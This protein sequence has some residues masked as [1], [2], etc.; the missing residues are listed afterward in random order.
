[1]KRTLGGLTSIK[2]VN[3]KRDQKTSGKKSGREEQEKGLSNLSSDERSGPFLRRISAT[4]N[5]LDT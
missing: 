1:M 4:W 5:S 3:A 2:K